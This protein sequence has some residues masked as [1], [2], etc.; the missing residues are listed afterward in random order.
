MSQEA[1]KHLGLDIGAST[2]KVALVDN[3]GRALYLDKA[4][5]S[6]G[7]PGKAVIKLLDQLQL[8]APDFQNIA[9]AG[10]TGRGQDL[11]KEQEGVAEVYFS[12]CGCQWFKV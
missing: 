7:G 1:K 3:T 11:Y 10:I 2:V 9:T 8:A 12:L 5:I 4:D 6:I